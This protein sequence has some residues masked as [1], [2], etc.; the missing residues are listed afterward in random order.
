MAAGLRR[1][2]FEEVTELPLAD[3]GEGTLATLLAAA[4]AES[5]AE[6]TLVASMA[7]RTLAV[8]LPERETDAAETEVPLELLERQLA[9]VGSHLRA[10]DHKIALYENTVSPTP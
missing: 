5:P 6:R 2:G 1:A 10:I 8:L 7:R 9:E 3:G 4:T